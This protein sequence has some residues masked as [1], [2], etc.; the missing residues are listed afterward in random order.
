ML[1]LVNRDVITKGKAKDEYRDL[2]PG[3]IETRKGLVAAIKSGITAIAS[4]AD[5]MDIVSVTLSEDSQPW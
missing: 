3:I 2:E 5:N 1:G 4:T